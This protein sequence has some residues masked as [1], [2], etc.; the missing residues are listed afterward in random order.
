MGHTLSVHG[1]SNYFIDLHKN[2]TMLF[3]VYEHIMIKDNYFNNLITVQPIIIECNVEHRK[4]LALEDIVL[5]I[6]SSMPFYA[7]NGKTT[8][9]KK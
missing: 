4:S 8:T 5:T 1:E 2:I 9:K 6:S 7:P 3:H